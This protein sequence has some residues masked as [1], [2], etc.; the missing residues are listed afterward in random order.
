MGGMID[1]FLGPAICA[2]RSRDFYWALSAGQSGKYPNAPERIF[3]AAGQFNPLW[4]LKFFKPSG[5]AHESKG[6]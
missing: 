6:R 3:S 4:R 2:P 1:A 5:I